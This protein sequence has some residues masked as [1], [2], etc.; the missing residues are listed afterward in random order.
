MVNSTPRDADGLSDRWPVANG[1]M[2]EW[3][4]CH[5][6]LRKNASNKLV[7]KLLLVNGKSASGSNEF[8]KLFLLNGNTAA[9]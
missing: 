3:S 1:S 7:S 4:A 6:T 8:L 2:N 5:G 9:D